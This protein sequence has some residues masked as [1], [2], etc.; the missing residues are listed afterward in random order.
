M[1][2]APV[3][4]LKKLAGVVLLFGGSIETWLVSMGIERR[5]TMVIVSVTKTISEDE[6][7]AAVAM[8]EYVADAMGI[9]LELCSS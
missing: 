2:P 7:A 6:S 5:G 9:L 8:E 1:E 4:V 3:G